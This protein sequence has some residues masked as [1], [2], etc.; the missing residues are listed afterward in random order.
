MKIFSKLFGKKK[1]KD[2]Q[3]DVTDQKELLKCDENSKLHKTD[4]GV[5]MELSLNISPDEKKNYEVSISSS[6]VGVSTGS[7]ATDFYVY[8][9]FIKE[10]GEIFYVGKGI[11]N[12]YKSF[13]ERAYEAEKIRNMFDTSSR[14]VGTGLTEEQAIELE[15][16]EMARI[17]NETKDRL[18]NRMI[19][20]FAER[21]N[22]YG[23][24]PETPALQ[25]E[26]APHLYASEIEEHYFGL[27]SRPF[28]EIKYENL[29]A[30]VFITRN[31]RDEIS[32]IYGGMFENYLDEVKVLLLTNSRKV[33]KSKFAKSVTAWIYV[34]DDYVTNYENDQ[35]QALEKLGRNVPTYHLIDV[36]KFLKGRFGGVD[37]VCKEVVPINPIHNRVPLKQIKNR[38]NWEKGFDQGIPYWEEGDRERKAGNLE[39]ALELFDIARYNGYNAPA[40]YTSYAM[41]YRKLK[42]F[43]NEIA[44][45]EEAIERLRLEKNKINETTIMEFKERQAK[46]FSLKQNSSE[47]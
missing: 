46:A 4:F 34:G 19:P 40:L 18:T 29:K 30:V 21:D 44:I 11:G 10:T 28:D 43:D 31:L 23:R 33:L 41:A 26:T 14:F 15:S 1:K 42:D 6:P 35:K 37:T 3:I 27:K 25:F 39:R 7:T 22:G 5:S 2:N 9:W 12:R 20:L 17:L 16:K 24:G 36:W 8:E 32:V 13:H 38:R 47:R 45:I